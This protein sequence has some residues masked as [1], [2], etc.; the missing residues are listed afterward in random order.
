LVIGVK[1]DFPPFGY[2]D[3]QGHHAGYDV[4]VAERLSDLAFGDPNRVSYVCVTTTNRIPLLQSGQVDMIIAT[5]S[6]S[7]DRAKTIDYSTP[8]YGATGRLLVRVGGGITSLADLRGKTVVT[9]RG[10]VYVTWAQTCLKDTR[11]R[12]LDGMAAGVT[13]VADG[14]ASGFIF[15][16]AFLL[17]AETNNPVLMLT[18]DKFLSIPWGIGV[19]RNQTTLLTW[20]NGAL[21]RMKAGDDF[22][23]IL[24]SNI[25]ASDLSS[26]ASQVPR[27]QI[28]LSY[29]SAVNPA[30]NCRA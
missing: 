17:G 10:S 11:L 9:T 15:D 2:L 20:I 25:P 8:Y 28:T 19:R 23:R 1:C 18:P 13:A 16:D 22:Y 14:Q 24:Q 12:Q 7:K 4:Q 21:A 30:T 29:P 3:A 26:F 5:L 6:W 27:P